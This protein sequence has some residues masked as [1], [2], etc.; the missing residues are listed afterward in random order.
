MDLCISIVNFFYYFLASPLLD[1]EGSQPLLNFATKIHFS[2]NE[3][4][5]E[6]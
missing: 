3:L 4:D 6:I 1:S 5:Y 2:Y